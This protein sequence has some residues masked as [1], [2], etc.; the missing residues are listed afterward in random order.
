VFVETSVHTF[1]PDELVWA[2]RSRSRNV[3]SVEALFAQV[4]SEAAAEV[5]R[6]G[7]IKRSGP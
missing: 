4:A 7:L 6:A 3:E 2:G 5:E 1:D